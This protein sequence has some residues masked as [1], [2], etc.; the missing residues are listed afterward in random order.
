MATNQGD[1]RRLLVI[2]ADDYGYWPSYNKA[3]KKAKEQA[4]P[5]PEYMRV[6]ELI[7]ATAPR[8]SIGPAKR[9]HVLSAF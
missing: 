1:T 6:G 3:S 4:P 2:T 7:T 9:S 8:R 5:E